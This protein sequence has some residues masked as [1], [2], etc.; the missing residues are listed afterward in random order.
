M[1]CEIT[2][3]QQSKKKE[4]NK[5][6]SNQ[7]PQDKIVQK[8]CALL[9]SGGGVLKIAISDH[10]KFPRD[11]VINNFNQQLDKVWQTYEQKLANL[12]KPST[13]SDVFHARSVESEEI[14]LVINAPQHLCTMHYNLCFAGDTRTHEASFI[15][16][17]ELLQNLGNFGKKSLNNGDCEYNVMLSKLR[18]RCKYGECIGCVESR[19]IQFKDFQGGGSIL[20]NHGQRQKVQKWIC[21]FANTSGGVILLGITDY[22]KIV[23]VDAGKEGQ[24][25]ITWKVIGMIKHMTFPITPERK[26][27]WDIEFIPVTGCETT[28]DRA[29]VAIKVARIGGVFMKDPVSYE[30]SD[31]DATKLIEFHQWKQ[32]M[33]SG[34]KLQ[35]E[36]KGLHFL[37]RINR[38]LF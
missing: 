26:I 27:H 19:Q 38:L 23:G 30:L 12:V 25:N 20:A 10:K 33:L 11:A 28:Q 17:V 7:S 29:V 31:H 15:Q 2:L 1:C 35:T 16:V 6:E 18:E 32:R 14:L 24:D 3:S 34:P 37:F 8:A 21:A 5:E 4:G 22:G 9:N 13:Y 36:L